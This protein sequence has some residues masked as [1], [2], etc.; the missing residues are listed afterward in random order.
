MLLREITTTKPAK[1]P[2]NEALVTGTVIAIATVLLSQFAL[3]VAFDWF[4]E[5]TKDWLNSKPLRNFKPTGNHIP[6]KTQVT[7]T[8]KTGKEVRYIYDADSGEWR[9]RR[10]GSSIR[11]VMDKNTKKPKV[12]K[13]TSSMWES[14]LKNKRAVF[15]DKKALL[16]VIQTTSINNASA[17]DLKQFSKTGDTLEDL[18]QRERQ[19]PL[20]R[21]FARFGRVASKMFSTKLLTTLNFALPAFAAYNAISLQLTYDEYLRL[22]ETENFLDPVTGK[23]YNKDHYDRDIINLRTVTETYIAVYVAS[24]GGPVLAT[25]LMMFLMTFRR[26]KIQKVA[27]RF[28][29]WGKMLK[30][31]R[32]GMKWLALPGGAVAVGASVN[33]QI[34]QGIGASIAG[35]LVSPNTGYAY[36][37]SWPDWSMHI[38]GAIADW[39]DA[40]WNDIMINLGFG[41]VDQNKEKEGFKKDKDNANQNNSSSNSNSNSSSNQS[42]TTVPSGTT[43]DSKDLWN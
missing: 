42:S 12:I 39:F 8:T 26:N 17:T 13:M 40:D 9:Q 14:A 27:E 28:G 21:K 31:S 34:A 24:L 22:G 25:A 32:I 15:L 38:P 1:E 2:L 18:I 5:K 20:A 29:I 33:P 35:A 3:G 30:I 23:R 7:T 41:T 37:R 10:K 11:Y 16:Q 36:T 4:L 6:N 43:V 19:G